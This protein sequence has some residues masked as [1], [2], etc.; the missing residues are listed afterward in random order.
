MVLFSNSIWK[1]ISKTKHTF[2]LNVGFIEAFRISISYHESKWHKN[3]Q[4]TKRTASTVFT[5]FEKKK[6]KKT[7][8][9][10]ILTCSLSWHVARVHSTA[11][12]YFDNFAT[13][14]WN[15]L[16]DFIHIVFGDAL[17]LSLSLL[18]RDIASY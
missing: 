17:R 3:V 9:L 4:S 18:H 7:R 6:E 5:S 1:C 15:I 10:F 14:R 13:K 11:F 8:L 12:E 2:A 16:L